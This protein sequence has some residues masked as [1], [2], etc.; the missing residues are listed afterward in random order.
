MKTIKNTKKSHI[1]NR[2]KDITISPISNMNQANKFRHRIMVLTSNRQESSDTHKA[3]IPLTSLKYML[4]MSPFIRPL[5]SI[6]FIQSIKTSHKNIK[7]NMIRITTL[8]TIQII[9]I[10]ITMA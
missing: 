8:Q 4:I 7:T 1:I 9:E 10:L 3:Q 5:L 6:H 2:N